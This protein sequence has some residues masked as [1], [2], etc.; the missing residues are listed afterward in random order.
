MIKSET[1]LA[2]VVSLS[3]LPKPT[4]RRGN[5]LEG[6]TVYLPVKN[7]IIME[8]NMKN[9]TIVVVG[10]IL[11]AGVLSACAG[12]ASAQ[13]LAPAAQQAQAT[14][15]PRSVIVS[16]TG[17][18]YL[19]PDIA[20]VTIGVHTEGKDAGQAVTSNNTKSKAVSDALKALG[21]DPKD[22]Q[23]TNFSIYPQQQYDPQGKATGEII[24]MVDNSVMVT[25]R[26]LSKIGDVLDAVV[27]AGANSI[28]GIQYDV[29]DR[30]KALAQARSLAVADAQNQANQLAKAAGVTLGEVVTINSSS[31][32]PTPMYDVK[33]IGGGG[34]AVAAA[35]PT[36]PVSAG[37]LVVI[38]NVDMVFGIQ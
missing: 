35:A 8:E 19:T 24:Y 23:T 34:A 26:D 30:E 28:S 29:A 36:V 15:T 1:G 11:I 9:K 4:N 18:V 12:V 5:F 14:S 37:Q 20:Y 13:S 2:T 3:S 6:Q 10:L 38:V 32:T 21:V 7:Y 33:G 22:I 25:V 17:K 27:K 31:T 16:G